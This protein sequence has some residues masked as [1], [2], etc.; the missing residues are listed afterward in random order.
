MAVATNA[1][2]MLNQSQLAA[3]LGCSQVRV[4]QYTRHA[5]WCFGPAPWPENLVSSIARWKLAH[6][7]DA[8]ATASS[9]DDNSTDAESA[10]AKLKLNPERYARVRLTLERT[11]SLKFQREQME[12]KLLDR[13]EVERGRVQRVL[14]VRSKLEELSSR[15]ALI[16]MKPE[17]ECA[18]I[19]D[20]WAKEI[21]NHFAGVTI[22]D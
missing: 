6:R 11:A 20:Q 15:S 2:A 4:S 18:K 7:A 22:E 14:A 8:N 9:T 3:R 16:A 1:S 21:C 19:L 17:T 5:D 13:D 12:G 10:I